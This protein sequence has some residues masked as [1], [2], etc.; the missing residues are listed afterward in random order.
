MVT[1]DKATIYSV[2]DFTFKNYVQLSEVESRQ[3][4]EWRNDPSIRQNMYTTNIIP[5][6]NHCV[7]IESLREREDRYY[8]QVSEGNEVLGSMNLVDVNASD[9]TAELGYFMRPDLVG[10][11]KGFYLIFSILEFSFGVLDFKRLYGATN[12]DNRPATLLDE[13]FGFKKTGEKELLINSESQLFAEHWLYAEDFLDRKEK[14]KDIDNLLKFMRKSK[15]Q[16]S[17]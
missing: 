2:G 4:L 1:I 9:G 3:I 15:K 13:Y 17:K 14:L 11:G 16:N 12:V 6:E 7:F 5:W 10:G 8:W